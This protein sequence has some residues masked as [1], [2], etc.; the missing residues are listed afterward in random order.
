MMK[1]QSHRGILIV[2]FFFL[3]SLGKSS[4]IL[5]N[6][7]S[8]FSKLNYRVLPGLTQQSIHFAYIG[9]AVVNCCT[10][11]A[12]VNPA[13]LQEKRCV[14]CGLFLLFRSAKIQMIKRTRIDNYEFYFKTCL[15]NSK[16]LFPSVFISIQ[17]L[18]GFVFVLRA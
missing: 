3:F 15:I 17:S 13:L 18:W 5:E 11:R 4:T 2:S 14:V 12:F 7:L 8:S 9:V 16:I 10:H 6:V 1:I